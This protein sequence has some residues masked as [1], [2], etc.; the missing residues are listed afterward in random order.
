MIRNVH[1]LSLALLNSRQVYE[2]NS[3]CHRADM[4]FSQ[5]RHKISTAICTEVA[6][7]LFWKPFLQ[8]LSSFKGYAHS[9]RGF[10]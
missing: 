4:I 9:A 5:G 1:E 8:P 10:Y 6:P 7:N 2:I 3:V